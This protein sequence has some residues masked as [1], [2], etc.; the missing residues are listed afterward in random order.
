M[1][2]LHCILT[3]TSIAHIESPTIT[4]KVFLPHRWL[5]WWYLL[6][7]GWFLLLQAM[8]SPIH[9]SVPPFLGSV[10]LLVSSPLLGILELL[11]AQSVQLF[12]R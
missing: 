1:I 3:P 11:L 10:L 2:G 4:V 12:T 9:L 6:G 7:A 5:P 8:T